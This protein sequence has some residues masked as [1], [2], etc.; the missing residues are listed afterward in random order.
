MKCDRCR[1]RL[2]QTNDRV[3]LIWA[4]EEAAAK[5]SNTPSIAPSIQ[6]K[7]TVSTP[8]DKYEQE[9]DGTAAKIMAMPDSAIQ[10]I[11]R[12]TPNLILQLLPYSAPSRAIEQSAPN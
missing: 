7:L 9:A 6:A 5:S 10:S 2:N 8:G 12:S 4:R 3:L 1:G 11:E